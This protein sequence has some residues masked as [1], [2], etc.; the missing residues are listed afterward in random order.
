MGVSFCRPC[1]STSLIAEDHSG[2]GRTGSLL[3]LP[4]AGNGLTSSSNQASQVGNVMVLGSAASG[5]RTR[6]QQN[7]VDVDDDGG[8]PMLPML[9]PPKMLVKNYPRSL[10]WTTNVVPAPPIGTNEPVVE[11][12]PP[13]ERSS[14]SGLGQ[15][16]LLQSG[17]NKAGQV[18][19]SDTTTTTTTTTTHSNEMSPHLSPTE[20]DDAFVSSPVTQRNSWYRFFGKQSL[21]SLGTSVPNAE[22]SPVFQISSLIPPDISPLNLEPN[23]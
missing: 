13:G 15:L 21:L 10:V 9:P 2:G 4:A 5:S 20:H 16:L 8:P 14:P 12:S 7:I 18:G 6:T 1:A 17:P 3:A 22:S 19:F 11:C 23:P